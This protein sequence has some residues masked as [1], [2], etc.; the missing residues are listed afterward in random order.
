MQFY[1]YPDGN[2]YVKAGHGSVFESKLETSASLLEWWSPQK[3]G[4]RNAAKELRRLLAKI[5]PNIRSYA[6]EKAN[7]FSNACVTVNVLPSSHNHPLIT[8]ITPL[9]AK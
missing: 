8:L 4:D 9:D 5:L 1:R 2:Y 7:Y 3:T 6:A